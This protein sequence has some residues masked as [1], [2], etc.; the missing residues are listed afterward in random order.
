[1]SG[2]G[3]LLGRLNTEQGPQEV[4]ASGIGS[5]LEQDALGERLEQ[6]GIVP[7]RGEK[8]DAARRLEAELLGQRG[9]GVASRRGHLA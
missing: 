4:W 3:G 9:S 2:G 8:P 6:L 1:M 5:T 7:R